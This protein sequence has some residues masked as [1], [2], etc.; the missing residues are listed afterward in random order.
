MVE[1]TSSFHLGNGSIIA[2]SNIVNDNM[3]HI[4]LEIKFPSFLRKHSCFPY[5][6]FKYP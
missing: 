6:F 5:E 4:I 3:G 1:I 2:L